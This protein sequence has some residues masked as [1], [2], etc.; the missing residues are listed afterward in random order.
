MDIKIYPSKIGGKI[1]AQPSKSFLN[2]ALLC[3]ALCEEKTVIK[4]AGLS[5]DILTMLDCLKALGADW[6]CSLDGTLIIIP[7]A[8]RREIAHIN[9]RESGSALRFL[10]P[11]LPLFAE[12]CTVEMSEGLSK[13]PMD[14]FIS[15]LERFGMEIK[16]GG[17]S[18]DVRGCLKSG[19]YI[20][21]GD[22]SS[23]YISALMLALPRVEGDSAIK[24]KG[25]MFS[26][27]YVE[28]SADMLSRFGAAVTFNENT[29]FI[30]GSQQYKAPLALAAQGDWSN[31]APF[32]A[33]GALSGETVE[34]SG[35]DENSKQGD[36]SIK[37]F[38]K[39]IQA[40]PSP[41]TI[42]LSQNPDLAPTL[43]AFAAVCEGVTMFTGVKRLK[44]KESDRLNGIVHLIRCL[45]GDAQDSEDTISVKGKGRLDGGIAEAE[46][47]HRTVM[48]AAVASCGCRGDVIIKDAEAVEKSYPSFFE[49]FKAFGGK[50]NV[51]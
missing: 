23:Q 31:A 45:G 51:I 40:S 15:E 34:I 22:I 18:Y 19:E 39:D 13:R 50:F 46:G 26:R 33:M 37:A 41:R 48:A 10:L 24:I 47:D 35:L 9:C 36:R 2:R 3:A 21:P 6:S 28:M 44:Y 43:A 4:N 5:G 17:C 27:P 30:S 7:S 25:S 42:D 32:L 20:L 11:C 14:V 49:D 12:N 8:E 1:S 38:L 16:R 29:I